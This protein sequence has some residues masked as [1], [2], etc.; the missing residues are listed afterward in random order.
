[1]FA[2]IRKRRRSFGNSFGCWRHSAQKIWKP[3]CLC[4]KNWKKHID[5]GIRKIGGLPARLLGL[6]PIVR[7]V[8][9]YTSLP[10]TEQDEA[11]EMGIT[12]CLE[13]VKIA[14]TLRD[15]PCLAFYLSVLARGY[16]DCHQLEAARACLEEALAIRR[17]LAQARPEVYR[18]DVATTLDSLGI[19]LRQLHQLEAAVECLEEAITIY[20]TLPVPGLD[21]VIPLHN[22]AQL[23]E[24]VS[25]RGAM[26]AMQ[27]YERAVLH[28]EETLALLGEV[29]WQ[30]RDKFKG[31]IE[32]DYRA[33]IEYYARQHGEGPFRK[34][35][36]LIESQRNV[37]AL[38]NFGMPDRLPLASSAGTTREIRRLEAQRAAGGTRSAE[39][40][41]I[42][43]EI[44]AQ[45]KQAARARKTSVEGVLEGVY[46]ILEKHRSAFLAMQATRDGE[47]V[48]L[49]ITPE[50]H[51]TD[52]AGK[53]FLDALD[54]L[55]VEVETGIHALAFA[56]ST[57]AP[58][59]T[60]QTLWRPVQR[61]PRRSEVAFNQL[62]AKVQA[63]LN[64]APFQTIFLAPDGR[65]VNHPFELLISR[66]GPLG[67]THLMPHVH[68]FSALVDVLQRQPLF[69]STGC[70]ALVVGNPLHEGARP[71]GGA[72]A[73][74]KHV[75]ERL[76]QRRY[77]FIPDDGPL[78]DNLATTEAFLTAFEER[79]VFALYEGHGGSDDVGEYLAMAGPGK[80]RPQRMVRF[81]LSHHPAIHYDCCI[82]GTTRYSGGGRF[83]G[84]PSA[85]MLAGA[86]CCLS[87]VYPI[88]DEPSR[89]F[90]CRLYDKLLNEDHPAT[91]GEALLQT[92]QE[93]AKAYGG[94][95]LAWGLQIF[96]GNPFV[97]LA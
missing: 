2:E 55:F 29:E 16:N 18:P 69:A 73:A 41:H 64:D 81:G 33:L 35:F 85:V 97:R 17:Q 56:A 62:P 42:D 5:R 4:L 89:E 70:T 76:R 7:L 92:R 23:E 37:E 38:A 28:C 1:M 8:E 11:L 93:M 44:Q 72:Q 48:F 9:G 91:F 71:L 34:L 15:A 94:N 63:L 24:E 39:M 27:L 19:A 46:R 95:P 68:G 50:E 12:C 86:S 30:H 74:A 96:W 80:V 61:I 20:D 13:A 40:A 21:K 51:W 58:A 59:A 83:D 3:S 45:A 79:P 77:S 22:L 84:H 52:V 43:T 66:N 31:D 25:G 49:G 14:Q 47:V 54:V 60:V 82:A 6:D 88:F 32:E 57:K 78:L 65:T 67:L 26:R 90:T 87:S 53:E 36:G 75:A 10:A